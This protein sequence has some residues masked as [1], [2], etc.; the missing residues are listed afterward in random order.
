MGVSWLYGVDGV[1]SF[2]LGDINFRRSNSASIDEWRTSLGIEP[3]Q[4]KS[5]IWRGKLIGRREGAPSRTGKPVWFYRFIPQIKD[6]LTHE[7]TDNEEWVSS[8]V[9]EITYRC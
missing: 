7:W 6:P 4:Y 3:E 9:I 5:T 1:I 8:D 2:R